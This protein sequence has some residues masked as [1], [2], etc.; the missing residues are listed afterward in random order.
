MTA[1]GEPEEGRLYPHQL[2]GP[3]SS[4]QGLPGSL[5]LP[6]LCPWDGGFF[7]GGQQGP[8]ESGL[9][10]PQGSGGK[11]SGRVG[12]QDQKGHGDLSCK[13]GRLSVVSAA[14]C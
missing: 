2:L 6:P 1:W 3:K 8:T 11:H 13:P 7:S 9:L 10:S 4:S 14:I 5:C 12:R